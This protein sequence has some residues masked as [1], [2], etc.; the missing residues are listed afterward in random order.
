MILVYITSENK[1]QAKKIAKHLL[2]KRLCAC[3]NIFE[4]MTSCYWWPPKKGKLEE[5]KEVVLIVKTLEN[6]FKAI[7]KEVKKV[8]SYQVPCIFSIKVDKAHKPYL[9][10]LKNEVKN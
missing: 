1:K 2:K 7:E 9:D 8:H 6:K 3:I 5:S 10:W 4:N